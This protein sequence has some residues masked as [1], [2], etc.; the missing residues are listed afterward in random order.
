MSIFVPLLSSLF[1]VNVLG[2]D[3]GDG[4]RRLSGLS[5]GIKTFGDSSRR[6]AED[7]GGSTRRLAASDIEPILLDDDKAEGLGWHHGTYSPCLEDAHGGMFH[8][9]WARDKG[10]VNAEYKFD[11]PRDG[12]YVIEEYHPGQNQLCSRYLPKNARVDVDYCKGKSTYTYV[13]QSQG[14]GKWNIVG[15]LPFFVGWEG[16]IK[17]A[18]NGTAT[19][20]PF[21]KGCFWIADAFKVTWVSNLSYG[22][23]V[24]DAM[25]EAAARQSEPTTVEPTTSTTTVEPTILTE[26]KALVSSSAEAAQK[27]TLNPAQALAAL[28]TVVDD[29]GLNFSKSW[30]QS[31]ADLKCTSHGWKQSFLYLDPSQSTDAGDAVEFPFDPPED[32]CYVVEEFHPENQCSLPFSR[33]VAFS[34]HYCKGLKKHGSLDQT[35]NGNQWNA[36]GLYPFYKGHRGKVLIS[37]PQVGSSIAVADAVRFTRVSNSCGNAETKAL[38]YIRLAQ[39]APAV[40]VDN[41]QPAHSHR[42]ASDRCGRGA[43]G[44]HFHAAAR[45][46][47]KATFEFEP[48]S[49]GCYRID[50]YHPESVE[51]KC[52]LA[53][54]SALEV[55]WCLG[56]RKQ[57]AFPLK[58]TGNRWNTVGHFK[59]YAGTK[60]NVISRRASD[61]VDGK[62]WVAD[63]VRFTKVAESCNAIPNVGLITLHINGSKLNSINPAT[64]DSGLTSYPDLR[65]A[66]HEA[67]V[68]ATQL[69][70]DA[71]RLLSLRKGSIIADFE[72][73]G[74]V[75]MVDRFLSHIRSHLMDG[76][77]SELKKALCLAAMSDSNADCTVTIMDSRKIR[78][79][80]GSDDEADSEEPEQDSVMILGLL[81]AVPLFA[82]VLVMACIVYRCCRYSKDKKK[83]AWQDPVLPITDASE[84][85]FNGKAGDDQ[86]IDAEKGKLDIDLI[87]LAS[88]NTPKSFIED[89]DLQSV[90][91]DPKL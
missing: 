77:E 34:I 5:P 16:R 73:R 78:S 62:Y 66:L 22:C 1:F 88:T 57:F 13:D 30:R 56:L 69:S 68:E 51:E 31:D 90:V 17:V 61:A 89:I 42:P 7:C 49:T 70:H 12:C 20:C 50:S 35:R 2:E 82:G 26:S 11:P 76:R 72:V 18:N 38:Q 6:L 28:Q 21:G 32:G 40:V 39:N 85:S 74:T 24:P 36:V 71:V 60:G 41:L 80:H 27:M 79:P 91:S 43:I 58:G 33:E 67:I 87:S 9:D 15:A 44:G 47:A 48:A 4:S 81:L 14:G 75:A 86:C 10:R 19:T 59:Y 65:I 63:A 64:L 54:Q 46:D 45:G 25:I 84:V 55:N 8:H 53:D 23:R 37:H 83:V 52:A 29:I 3:C